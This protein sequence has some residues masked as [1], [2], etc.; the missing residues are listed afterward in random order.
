MTLKQWFSLT[1]PSLDYTSIEE[2]N[3]RLK[4]E[5]AKRIQPR[6]EP[7]KVSVNMPR[8]LEL[9][10]EDLK[11]AP[12]D[13]LGCAL[14]VLGLYVSIDV[15]SVSRLH[16]LLNAINEVQNGTGAKIEEMMYEYNVGYDQSDDLSLV[17]SALL[18]Q[19]LAL[20]GVPGEAFGALYLQIRGN[21]NRGFS[22][23]AKANTRGTVDAGN[24]N[25]APN[26]SSGGPFD[27]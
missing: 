17:C 6:I 26:S 19:M 5:L 13:V 25:H 3:A 23:K 1:S 21:R 24:V 9:S 11:S 7:P 14:G 18:T 2:E 20:T 10:M 16:E 22:R 15:R 8:A 4:N 12:S 27:V